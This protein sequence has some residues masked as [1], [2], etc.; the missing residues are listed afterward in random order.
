VLAFS[1]VSGRGRA[2]KDI[3]R[4]AVLLVG[5]LLPLSLDSAEPPRAGEYEIK[6]AF[7]YKFIR[8]TEWPADEPKMSADAFVI[9]V[10]GADP[11]GSTLDRMLEGE[12][13]GNKKIVARRFARVEDATDSHVLFISSSSQA[14]LPRILKTLESN[15]V[16]SVS[17]IDSFAQRG[18]IIALKKES[19]RIVF[20]INLD[21]AKRAKL[22]LS[23]QLL[24]LARIVKEQS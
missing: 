13:I 23:S 6:A 17:E 18:G 5:F 1:F 21:A 3:L 24:G 11:F 14:E 2:V 22:T 15:S 19:N 9:G 16:L 4:A 20:E 7:L 12:L 8:F 10:L